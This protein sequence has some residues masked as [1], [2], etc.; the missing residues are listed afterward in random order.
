MFFLL[1]LCSVGQKIEQCDSLRCFW[2]FEEGL[3]AFALELNGRILAFEKEGGIVIDEHILVAQLYDKKQYLTRQTKKETEGLE[4]EEKYL[5]ESEILLEWMKK[6]LRPL[7]TDITVYK[8]PIEGDKLWMIIKGRLPDA[9]APGSSGENPHI[10]YVFQACTVSG[11][12]ILDI[13]TTQYSDQL[14]D[15]CYSFLLEVIST[16]RQIQLPGDM[17]DLCHE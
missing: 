1:S 16:Y 10:E 13:T 6:D 4:A 8:A 11:N 9:N 2:V 17:S 3:P 5:L 15:D 14:I 7:M 12:K